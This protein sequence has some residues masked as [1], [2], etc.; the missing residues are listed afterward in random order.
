MGTKLEARIQQFKAAA[1]DGNA[2]PA[3]RLGEIRRL[4]A[5]LHK[6]QDD[7]YSGPTRN[8]LC[9][10]IEQ[11]HLR[12]PPGCEALHL[13]LECALKMPEKMFAE[14]HKSKFL[15]WYEKAEGERKVEGGSGCAER[16]EAG[17]R[18]GAG[19]VL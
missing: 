3:A 9:V 12:S 4:T 6:H 10:A 8:A 16:A 13:L 18:P 1:E 7:A 14:S 11:H 15:R 19:L 2:K 17:Q 5:F